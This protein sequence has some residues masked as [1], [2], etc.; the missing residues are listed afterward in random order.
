MEGT[1]WKLLGES[2]LT[3]FKENSLNHF[4]VFSVFFLY[5]P[6]LTSR[7]RSL[8]LWA[9]SL[10]DS[11]RWLTLQSVSQLKACNE[12]ACDPQP[13]ATTPPD[14]QSHHPLSE[15]VTLSLF[16][17]THT[18]LY[19]NQKNNHTQKPL[20]RDWGGRSNFFI[21]ADAS[22]KGTLAEEWKRLSTDVSMWESML[23]TVQVRLL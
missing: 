20:S 12:S 19:N 16:S 5:L 17:N 11:E 2:S 8:S 7:S 1:E 22:L 18:H 10:H 13:A 15:H 4:I 21:R 3:F 14:P 6:F 9:G 23:E